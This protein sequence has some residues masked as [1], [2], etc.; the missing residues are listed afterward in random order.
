MYPVRYPSCMTSSHG[1]LPPPQSKT[2]WVIDTLL[3]D[4]GSGK[5]KPGTPLRVDELAKRLGVSSTPVREALRHLS[6]QRVVDIVPH[7][8]AT[9][10]SMSAS[11][12]NVLYRMRAELES[13]AAE[14][15]ASDAQPDAVRHIAQTH[16]A[17]ASAVAQHRSASRLAELNREFHFA[18]FD[19]ASELVSSTIN[20]LWN[21]IPV[22][23]HNSLWHDRANA[24]AFVEAHEAILQA[25][26]DHNAPLAAKLMADHAVDAFARRNV[27]HA[28][29]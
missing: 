5:L 20:G 24:G 4:I 6:A 25:I 17:L 13:L 22:T 12:L 15:A 23:M 19:A 26:S 1:A 8:G 3:A 16:K 21:L 2:K 28:D 29:T 18:V 7:R 11:D 9:V 14:I 10:S 27:D